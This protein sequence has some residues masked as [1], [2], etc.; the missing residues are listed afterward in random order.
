IHM[1]GTE[2]SEPAHSRDTAVWPR[3]LA[4]TGADLLVADGSL[5]EDPLGE[6]VAIA[7]PA[8]LD[9]HQVAA[10]Q[11]LR[12]IQAA[13]VFDRRTAVVAQPRPASMAT[14]VQADQLCALVDEGDLA[15]RF[16]AMHAR[17][18][19]AM[20]AIAH[21][22]EQLDRARPQIAPGLHDIDP[23]H[24]PTL[25]AFHRGVAPLVEQP[26]PL[27]VADFRASGATAARIVEHQQ[28]A[29]V[30]AVESVDGALQLAAMPLLRV[31]RIRWPVS[32]GIAAAVSTRTGAPRQQQGAC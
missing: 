4:R 25:Q 17:I 5:H 20:P 7:Q 14:A 26:G 16:L 21:I 9:A 24:V 27:V 30:G 19:A 8:R 3:H 1:D 32:A 11:I 18:A 12:P 2:R 23:H 10:V 6:P 13:T 15:A 31:A 22:A 29:S 28:D